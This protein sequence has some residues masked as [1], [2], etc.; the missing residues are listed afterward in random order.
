MDLFPYFE[1]TA[2][3][4]KA[5][6]S[7]V[8]RINKLDLV[9][10]REAEAGPD[11][12]KKEF[13]HEQKE[14]DADEAGSHFESLRDAADLANK[15]LEQKNSPYRFY[16]YREFDDIFI[17]LVILDKEENI[18]EVKKKNITHQEFTELISSIQ[19]GEGLLFDISG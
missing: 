7:N 8:D 16:V 11:N 5:A 2:A 12:K 9:R 10:T 4:D 6:G 19:N 18:V 13:H 17:N 3:A 15:E 14:R 1:R